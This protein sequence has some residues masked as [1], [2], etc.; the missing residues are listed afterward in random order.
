MT[1][2]Q[3][4]TSTRARAVLVQS[5]FRFYCYWDALASQLDV[6][7]DTRNLHKSAALISNGDFEHALEECLEYWIKNNDGHSWE[8]LLTAVENIER[9]GEQPHVTIVTNKMRKMLQLGQLMYYN[10]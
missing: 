4:L 2:S 6:P 10:S 7:I 8:M 9:F 1:S 5:G 3:K